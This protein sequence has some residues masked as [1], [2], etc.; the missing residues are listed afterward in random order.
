MRYQDWVT[1][2]LK[3]DGHQNIQATNSEETDSDL[4]YVP[5][6]SSS[7]S[8]YSS[9]TDL[10]QSLAS[11]KDIIIADR[12]PPFVTHNVRYTQVRQLSNVSFK[13]NFFVYIGVLG[14]VSQTVRYVSIT[15]IG[16]KNKIASPTIFTLRSVTAA[17]CKTHTRQ[18]VRCCIQ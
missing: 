7:I 15:Q 6:I 13:K 2:R 17:P 5:T 4:K 10:C 16:S 12:C 14:I 8:V 3:V 9:I 1:S 11:K 18:K